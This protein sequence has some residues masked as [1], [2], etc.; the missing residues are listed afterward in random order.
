MPLTEQQL[1]SKI[2]LL[3][4]NAVIITMD[5]KNSVIENGFIAITGNQIKNIGQD[6]SIDLSK[7]DVKR[8]IDLHGSI[9]HPGYIDSHIHLLY[10]PLRWVQKDGIHASLSLIHI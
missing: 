10:Q 6:K 7:Y 5:L 9:V 3:I 8:S 1:P 2:D 4:R